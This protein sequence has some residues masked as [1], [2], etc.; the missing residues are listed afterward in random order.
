MANI[1]SVTRMMT[2][3][4]H[5]PRNPAMMP[6]SVRDPETLHGVGKDVATELVGAHQVREGDAL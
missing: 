3:E 5:L 1:M 2:A 6:P 4:V